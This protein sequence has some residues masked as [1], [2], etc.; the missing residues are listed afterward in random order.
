MKQEIRVTKAATFYHFFKIFCV[1][2]DRGKE[3]QKRSY[4]ENLFN[5]AYKLEILQKAG[6][7]LNPLCHQKGR[8]ECYHRDRGPPQ[9]GCPTVTSLAGRTAHA[10]QADAALGLVD[11]STAGHFLPASTGQCPVDF[12]A[13]VVGTV[14]R[15]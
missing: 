3:Q 15:G 14:R 1:H 12:V 8:H 6:G 13:H 4:Y 2:T 7:E 10:G 11:A 9:A 5:I